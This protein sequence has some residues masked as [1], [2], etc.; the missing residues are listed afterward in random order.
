MT[1]MTFR[2]TYCTILWSIYIYIYDYIFTSALWLL[3][4]C[5]DMWLLH[6]MYIHKLYPTHMWYKNLASNLAASGSLTKLAFLQNLRLMFSKSKRFG[7][8]ARGPGPATYNI[9]HLF[10]DPGAQQPQQRSAL[11]A[12]RLESRFCRGRS[13]PWFARSQR[14]KNLPRSNHKIPRATT[15]TGETFLP[16]MVCWPKVQ[17]GD[18]GSVFQAPWKYKEPQAPWNASWSQSSRSWKP[19][20]LVSTRV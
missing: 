4:A 12:G 9:K 15:A 8:G 18:T 6:V 20:R 14:S 16:A 10:D 3:I 19:G 17:Q 1:H 13:R 5:P 7:H 2:C 11:A